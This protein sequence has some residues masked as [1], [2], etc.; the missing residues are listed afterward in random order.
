MEDIQDTIWDFGSKIFQDGLLAFCLRSALILIIAWII[1]HLVHRAFR[2]AIEKTE[3]R[4]MPLSF[5]GKIIRFI[6]WAIAVFAILDG[7]RPLSGLGS[8][9]LGA[10]SILSVVVGLAAQE[11]F[12]NFIAGFFIAI[13]QPFAVGDVV[14]LP[15]KNISGTVVEITFRHTILSTVQNTKLIIPNSVMNSAI[16]EDRAFGQ[17]TYTR[18]ISFDIGYDSDI[19]KAIR[20]IID[21]VMHTN[22]VIDIR[23]EEEKKQNADPITVRVEEFDASGIRLTFPLHTNDLGSSYNAASDVRRTLLKKFKENDIE[24]PY[25]KVEVLKGKDA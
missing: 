6:I 17:T 23:T 1:S 15:E 14:S 20:L 24:I 10:T 5:L 11:T 8:A 3:S 2:R 4:T 22:G 25:N 19:D 13:Y 9:V 7:I 16:I 12:G 21:T 18:Y